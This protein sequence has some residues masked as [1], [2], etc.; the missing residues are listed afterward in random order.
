MA[1]FDICNNT[2][3]NGTRSFGTFTSLPSSNASCLNATALPANSTANADVAHDFQPVQGAAKYL[4][5]V[6]YVSVFFFGVFGNM[7]V[8]YVVGYR[9][10]KRSGGDLYILSLACADFLSSIFVPMVML[11]DLLT[12]FSG[13]LYGE[14]MCYILPA[15]N[16]GTLSASS[17]SLVLISLDRYR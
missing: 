14:V 13:W 4:S 12:D 5:C 9:K 10:K 1:Q 2:A 16:P 8:F 15:I 3:T 17:W 6:F 7:I 11:N